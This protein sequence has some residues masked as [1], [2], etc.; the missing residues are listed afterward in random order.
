VRRPFEDFAP[1]ACLHNGAEIHDGNPVAHVLDNAEVVADHDVGEA[2]RFLQFQQQIDDLGTDRDIQRPNIDLWDRQFEQM[3][4]STFAMDSFAGRGIVSTVVD[5]SQPRRLN[6][7]KALPRTV[8][9][10]N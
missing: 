7:I 6:M 2:E 3:A 1:V 5:Q 10:L 4:V 8:F 9:K